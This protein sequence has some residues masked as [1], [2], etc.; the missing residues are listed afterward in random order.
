MKKVENY[1]KAVQRLDEANAEYLK[2]IEN[3][4]IRDGLIQR[5]EFTFELAWKAS[6]EYLI[7]QGFSNDLH[8]P[9]QVLRAAYENHMIDDEEVWLKMLDSRNRTSHIYDDRVAAAIAENITG[10]FLPVLLKLSDYFRGNE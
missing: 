10:S 1:L 5:F 6:K 4:V 7:D 8:F 9:K 2:N 3:D